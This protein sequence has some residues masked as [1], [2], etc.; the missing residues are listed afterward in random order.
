MEQ[1]LD[2]EQ[3]QQETLTGYGHGWGHHRRCHCQGAPCL[4]ATARLVV[5][6]TMESLLLLLL[7][8]LPLTS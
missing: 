4:G 5:K 3:V 6:A 1:K 2:V 7:L 8:S